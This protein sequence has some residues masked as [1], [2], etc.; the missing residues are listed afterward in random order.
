M[1]VGTEYS[2][3]AGGVDECPTPTDRAVVE[4]ADEREFELRSVDDAIG[5]LGEPLGKRLQMGGQFAGGRRDGID[6]GVDARI[7]SRGT[8]TVRGGRSADAVS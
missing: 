8:I 2:P 4:G 6:H 7:A 5:G 1:L 3:F